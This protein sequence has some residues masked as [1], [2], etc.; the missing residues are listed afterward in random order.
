MAKFFIDRP[1]F[2]W[3]IAILIMLGGGLSILKLPVAQYPAIAPPQIAVSA[4]YPGADAQTLENTVTQVI[5]QRLNG[6]DGLRYFTAESTSAGTVTI[7]ITFEPWVNPDIAQVQVQNKV[8][9]AEP[10]LPEEVKRQ[11][12]RVF[13][14]SRNFLQIFAFT[15]ADGSM[16]RND[17]ADYVASNI[18]DQVARIPGVGETQLFGAPYAMRIWLNPDKLTAFG[19]TPGDVSNA[20]R[21]QNTQISAGQL[22]GAPAV[23]GTTFN[24]TVT[25]QS[26]L[27]TRRGVSRHPPAG[28]R[29]RLAGAPRRRRPR[30]A[31]GRELRRRHDSQRQARRLARREARHRRQR[32]RHRRRRARS[33]ST[34]C[35]SS[36]RPA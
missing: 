24:A 20:V 3:V 11:G 16:G 33:G 2:A 6:I 19:L 22:G 25:A 32:P 35:R 15:S 4:I 10:L 34:R 9:T 1:I 21:E 23:P 12:L 36:S 27:T 14:T 13:K 5:E 26:R 30:R 7:N 28:Q 31:D 8:A 29:R 17:I 18:V